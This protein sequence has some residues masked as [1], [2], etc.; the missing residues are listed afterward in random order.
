MSGEV[1]HPR[2][3][4][5]LEERLR[6]LSEVE[7][8]HVATQEAPVAEVAWLVCS[9][10]KMVREVS[11]WLQ[12]LALDAEGP[13]DAWSWAWGDTGAPVGPYWSQRTLQALSVLL[14][15]ELLKR[16]QGR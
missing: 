15:P 5:L 4:V 14:R 8:V 3:L 12:E 9:P 10:E 7:E 16:V 2:A 6:A 1:P 11:A 13:G